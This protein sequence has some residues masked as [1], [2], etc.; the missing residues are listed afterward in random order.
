MK[1]ANENFNNYLYRSVVDAMKYRKEHNIVRPDM[2]NL[3]MEAQSNPEKSHNRE[4]TNMELVAQ[5]AIFLFAGLE[6]VST[7]LCFAAQ[8]LIE[9]PDIQ[10][11]N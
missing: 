5:C 7:T 1:I 11:K 9:H 8:E 4:W 3:L 10:K 6:S 2:I